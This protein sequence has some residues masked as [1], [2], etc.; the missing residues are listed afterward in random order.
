MRNAY[1]ILFFGVHSVLNL[2]IR[3]SYEQPPIGLLELL[4]WQHSENRNEGSYNACWRCHQFALYALC[5]EC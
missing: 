5:S 4:A 1:E 2:K 3:S